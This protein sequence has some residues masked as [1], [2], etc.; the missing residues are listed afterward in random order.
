LQICG[1]EA[2]AMRKKLLCPAVRFFWKMSIAL[3]FCFIFQAGSAQQAISSQKVRITRGEFIQVMARHQPLNP[4]FPQN[5]ATLSQDEFYAQTVKNLKIQGFNILEGKDPKSSLLD[6][7]FVMVTY[8]FSGAPAG[9]SLLEQKLYLKGAGIVVTPDIGL[10]TAVAGKVF[11]STDGEDFKRRTHLASPVFLK[12]KIDTKVDSKVSFAF[13]DASSISIGENAE[14]K[15]TKHIFD[16]NKNLRQTVVEVSLGAVRFAVTKEKNKDST[17]KVIT[18]A[19]IAGV[20]GTEF[21]VIVEP[22]G[23]TTFVGLEG[24][25]ETIPFTPE[26]QPG[27]AQIISRDQSQEISKSGEA[28]QVT[29]APSEI[30]QKAKQKTALKPSISKDQGVTRMKAEIAANA[31]KKERLSNEAEKESDARQG[32]DEKIP[33]PKDQ[34]NPRQSPVKEQGGNKP[35]S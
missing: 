12:D 31:A 19:G 4:L 2:L 9:K 25:I 8:A 35:I 29:K 30:L 14:V 27:K 10:A 26:G 16:P 13:D 20:R 1:Y 32:E 24:S 7:E 34:D 21:V 22:D 11:Q 5:G 33:S 15:I 6:I 23:K 18:P 28:S 3:V 17:F